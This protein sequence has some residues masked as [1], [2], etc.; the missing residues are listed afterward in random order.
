MFVR[1]L[2]SLVLFIFFLDI[3]NIKTSVRCNIDIVKRLQI[4]AIYNEAT[5]TD[6]NY[7]LILHVCDIIDNDHT[8][9]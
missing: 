6:L 8:L 9:F 7:L 4:F 1:R 2:T 5:E 3:M